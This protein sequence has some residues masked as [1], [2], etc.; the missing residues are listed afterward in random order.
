MML[1]EYNIGKSFTIDCEYHEYVFCFVLFCLEMKKMFLY[2]YLLD[3]FNK[4]LCSNYRIIILIV[5][6]S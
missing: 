3:L 5:I 1:C 2:I 4:L 6:E